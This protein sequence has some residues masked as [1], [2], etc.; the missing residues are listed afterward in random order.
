MAFEVKI[1]LNNGEEILWRY[2]LNQLVKFLH[3]HRKPT[4][5]R[6]SAIP[7]LP[8]VI[9]MTLYDVKSMLINKHV[10]KIEI[11]EGRPCHTNK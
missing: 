7:V 3:L 8:W 4:S 1:L 2:R 11:E 10:M 9:D 5:L 6:Q